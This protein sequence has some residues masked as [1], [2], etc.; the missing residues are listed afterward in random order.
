MGV[1]APD[2]YTYSP[3][4]AA[5]QLALFATVFAG[6]ATFVYKFYPERPVVSVQDENLC[7]F[8]NWIDHFCIW[9]TL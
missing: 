6:F 4:K 2:L 8:S 1:W 9:Q 7:I 5:S 3:Y